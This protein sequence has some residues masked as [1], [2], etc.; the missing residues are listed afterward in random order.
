MALSPRNIEIIRQKLTDSVNKCCPLEAT[1]NSYLPARLLDIGTTTNPTSKIILTEQFQN[2]ASRLVPQYAALSYCWGP[3]IEADQNLQTRNLSLPLFLTAI[4]HTLFPAVI[5]DTILVCRALSIRYL[6]VDTL[7]IIQ[8]DLADWQKESQNMGLVYLNALVTICPLSSAS[9][10]QGFLDRP[11]NDILIP[12][13]SRLNTRVRGTYK[14]EYQPTITVPT[15]DI[16]IAL[17]I[18]KSRWSKRG[19]TLQELYMSCRIL[20]FGQSRFHFQC[21]HEG[22]SEDLGCQRYSYIEPLPEA[23]KSSEIKH[24]DLYDKW[25]QMAAHYCQRDLTKVE[26]KLPAISGLASFFAKHIK[27]DYIVGLWK[28]DI[29]R[30][31]IWYGGQRDTRDNHIRRLSSPKPA[32]LPSWSCLAHGSSF[33]VGVQNIPL[34]DVKLFAA[35]TILPHIKLASSNPFGPINK[36]A[37]SVSGKYISLSSE[38]HRAQRDGFTYPSWDMKVRGSLVFQCELD[39]SYDAQ[40]FRPPSGTILFKI[41]TSARPS[42][43]SIQAVWGLVL[44]PAQYLG[45]YYRI[46]VFSTHPSS[47]SSVDLYRTVGLDTIRIV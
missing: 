46:G 12:F 3:K 24:E 5:K 41:S 45:D 6:W 20:Y 43:P 11:V 31:L 37:L 38:L 25:Y 15:E 14:L 33:E 19:W 35:C 13:Q 32:N 29:M 47:T 4:N 22:F 26:D 28:G 10:L 44:I 34:Y 23:L 1:T 2:R 40:R 8:D 7:C 36:A 42:R 21:A 30:G 17:D 9:C 18:D 16:D 27:E 39:F